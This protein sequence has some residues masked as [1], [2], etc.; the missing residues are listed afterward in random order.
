[1][2][3]SAGIPE[4]IRFKE[5]FWDYKIVVY[6][7]LGCDDIMFEVQVDTSKRINLLQG[8]VERHHVFTNLMCAMARRHFCNVCHK[9]CGSEITQ[10]ATRHVATVC[11]AFRARSPTFVSPATKVTDILEVG[12]FSLTR[13]RALQRETPF[14]NV[15]DITQR[16]E[17][18]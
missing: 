7:G 14:L 18:S 11:R 3:E 12:K 2:T 13:S 4:L 1:L 17:H 16:V 8:D 15:N 6:H 5:Q 9:I 10:S